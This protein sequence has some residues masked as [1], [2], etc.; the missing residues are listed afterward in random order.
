MNTFGHLKEYWFAYAFAVQL[1]LTWGYINHS[2]KNHEARIE[3]LE[4]DQETNE[5]NLAEIN[6]RLASIETSL[7]FIEKSL[8]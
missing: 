7:K 8:K 3:K 2:I 6:S 5:V 4:V 1:I